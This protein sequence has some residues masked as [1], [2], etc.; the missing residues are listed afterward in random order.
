MQDAPPPQPACPA[1][2]A[3][4]AGASLVTESCGPPGAEPRRTVARLPGGPG[5]MGSEECGEPG[6]A[7]GAPRGPAAPPSGITASAACSGPPAG[8][9]R[10]PG[11]EL[12]PLGAHRRA[13]GP[14]YPGQ[15]GEVLPGL[16]GGPPAPTS[17]QGRVCPHP[18]VSQGG[19][20]PFNARG[21][22]GDP[23]E[24]LSPPSAQLP[25]FMPAVC[26]AGLGGQRGQQVL[27]PGCRD[28]QA[29]Q[30]HVPGA[31]WGRP[32]GVPHEPGGRGE[33]AAG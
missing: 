31:G 5:Q 4:A 23:W 26:Q 18:Q 19:P 8:P 15:D 11:L 9:L 12:T 33:G 14:F 30:G 25:P 6:T 28:V 3:A 1:H 16:L 7:A 27:T 24:R 13:P 10:G 17:S 22:L 21:Q 2:A 20:C 29:S 32:A